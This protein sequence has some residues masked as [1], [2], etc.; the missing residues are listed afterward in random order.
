MNE[1]QIIGASAKSYD[2]IVPQLEDRVHR[3]FTSGSPSAELLLG[4]TRLNIIRAL[5]SNLEVLGYIP[6]QLDDDSESMFSGAS[7]RDSHLNGAALPPALQP[8]EIQRLVP[9]HPWLDLIPIPKLRDNLIL[10]GDLIDDIK[11]CHDLCGN[12]VSRVA[13]KHSSEAN[14]ETGLIVWKDPWDPSGWEITE[15]FFRNWG[16]ILQD[17][18]D[19]FRSTNA[20]R[21]RRGERPLFQLLSEE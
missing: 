7:P 21:N 18:W 13:P 3:E 9:H 5:H 1:C 10:A 2:L 12:S 15:T 20:W 8:T 19:L 11:L 14:G 16:W 6:A 17:C 4:L